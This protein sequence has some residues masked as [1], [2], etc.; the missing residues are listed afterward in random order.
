[1]GRKGSRLSL[2]GGTWEA[3]ILQA[4]TSVR[5]R[6]PYL[7]HTLVYSGCPTHTFKKLR[8]RMRLSEGQSWVPVWQICRIKVR[9]D[10]YDHRNE[11]KYRVQC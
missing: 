11:G 6:T 3:A 8:A 10:L 2:E 5:C 4:E 1:M 7:P 9:K